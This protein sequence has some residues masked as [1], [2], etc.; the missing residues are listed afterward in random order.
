MTTSL[1]RIVRGLMLAGCGALASYTAY[2][3]A[4]QLA[5]GS[6]EGSIELDG[7]PIAQNPR[8]RMMY[9]EL[10]IQRIDGASVAGTWSQSGG[11]CQGTHPVEGRLVSGRLFL[12][13]ADSGSACR[14][15][16]LQLSASGALEGTL[17]QRELRLRR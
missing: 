9:V 10:A 12:K 13:P 14:I 11:P 16:P 2:G 5:N 3:Q 15:P 4:E 6:Y 7:G 8:P 1:S 17:A